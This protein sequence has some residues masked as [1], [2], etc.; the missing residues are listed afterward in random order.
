MYDQQET[1]SSMNLIPDK[2]SLLEYLKH[3]NLQTYKWKQCTKQ[4]ITM[5]AL[6]G[7]GWKEQKGK[8]IPVWFLTSQLP[9][10]LS[11][12]SNRVEDSYNA[13]SEENDDRK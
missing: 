3:S 10:H 6:A 11:R 7:N 8:I 13:D 9:P 1:K 4:N 5:P 2:S 12:K